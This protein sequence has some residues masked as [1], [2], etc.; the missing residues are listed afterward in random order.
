MSMPTKARPN[1]RVKAKEEKE[2]TASRIGDK[3]AM[4]FGDQMDVNMVTIVRSI[5]PDDNQDDVQFV[6]LLDITSQC[7]R[8]VKPKA[9][10]AE[11]DEDS[12]WQAE[13]EWQEST[14]ENE[15]C[16]AS[17][18]K[19]GKGKRSKSK[20]K[21][22]GNSISRP[23]TPR[24]TQSQTPR[25]DRAGFLFAMMSTKSKP[26]WRH[27]TWNYSDYMVCTVIEPQNRLPVFKPG[28]W[29]ITSECRIALYGHDAKSVKNFT[30]HFDDQSQR[31]SLDHLWFREVWFPVENM[32]AKSNP[33][34]L[35]S[36]SS[37]T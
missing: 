26:T 28:K 24:P 18:G 20:E 21:S 19:K 13:A 3:H 7:T 29:S 6:D 22:N 17:K 9:K 16:E 5:T 34:F 15:A 2:R 37:R 32:C 11:H 23:I 8:P 14:W 31:G 25:T 27:A 30:L 12:N 33:P 36:R 1:R 35:C 10:N 4:T